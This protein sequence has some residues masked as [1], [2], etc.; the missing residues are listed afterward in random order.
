MMHI[1]WSFCPYPHHNRSNL[2]PVWRL[3]VRWV[4]GRI[5]RFSER[6]DGQ[7]ENVAR[8]TCRISY[9]RRD[10]AVTFTAAHFARRFFS[11]VLSICFFCFFYFKS[12]TLPFVPP[13]MIFLSRLRLS[14]LLFQCSYAHMF[15]IATE[16]IEHT[17]FFKALRYNL[18][19]VWMPD[20][21]SMQH[22]SAMF[23]ID[24]FFSAVA[25]K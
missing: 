4:V 9:Y 21:E 10:L 8:A 22:P 24:D 18:S 17:A 23:C 2:Q 25:A 1:R 14:K 16:K 20:I 13:S 3:N 15:H 11:A 5:A 7:R 6:R 19:R 12:F